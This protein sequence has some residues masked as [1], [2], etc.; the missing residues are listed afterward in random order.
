MSGTQNIDSGLFFGG[1]S[2]EI[3]SVI[4]PYYRV[5]DEIRRGCGIDLH[6]QPELVSLTA[7]SKPQKPL[8]PGDRLASNISRDDAPLENASRSPLNVVDTLTLRQLLQIFGTTELHERQEH[9]GVAVEGPHTYQSLSPNL[10]SLI[11][12]M[13]SWDQSAAMDGASNDFQAGIPLSCEFFKTILG[14]IQQE[15]SDPLSVSKNIAQAFGNLDG[16]AST[17]PQW[18]TTTGM[19]H[20]FSRYPAAAEVK[21]P[22]DHQQFAAPPSHKCK[23]FAEGRRDPV[24]STD[25]L[26]ESMSQSSRNSD[27]IEQSSVSRSLNDNRNTN[28]HGDLFL[29]GI[30]L[31][32]WVVDQL[33]RAAERPQTGTT[34]FDPRMSITW[35][36]AP[37]AV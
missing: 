29:D 11:S 36:G 37:V 12:D 27:A 32:R 5:L 14:R 15:L 9:T 21:L 8:R 25:R 2:S 13:G 34:G 4:W 22:N 3:L 18:P 19:G 28:V 7:H 33:N 20:A 31:G 30:H 16:L 6:Y 17:P 10:V 26:Y 35:P 23:A 1:P 24:P